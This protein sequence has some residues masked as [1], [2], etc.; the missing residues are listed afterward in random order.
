MAAL[1]KAEPITETLP[2]PVIIVGAGPVG[3]RAAQELRRRSPRLPLVIFGAEAW[4]PYN[5][6]RLSSAL[7]GEVSWASVSREV[8]LPQD[9]LTTAHFG[10]A[11]VAIERQ[12]RRIRDALG[13][14]H[15]YAALIL[16]TGSMP[17]VPDIPGTGLAGV[18]TFRDMND[19]QR[20]LARRVRSRRT[21]VLG[22][23]LL[24]LEAARAMRRFNTEVWVVEH[25]DRLMPRQLDAGA[26]EALIKHVRCAGIRVVLADGARAIVGEGRVEGVRLRSGETLACDTVVIATG[27]VPNTRLARQAGL[28]VGRGI[29][30]DDQ[31]RTSDPHIYAIGECAEHRGQVYGL[32]APGLEQ[33]AVVAHVITGGDARYVGSVTATRLKVL[34]IPVFSVGEAVGE[35]AFDAARHRVYAEPARGVYR[36]VVVRSGRLVGAI[37]VGEWSELSRL[38]EAVQSRRRVWPWQLARFQRTGLLWSGETRHS[39]AQWPSSA[40][41]CNCTGVTRGRLEEA[42][43]AG[44]A[45]VE[46]LSARTG[47]STVCGSCRPL[48]AELIGG[49][50]RPLPARGAKPL[51]VFSAIALTAA[52]LLAFWSMP[53][54]ETADLPWRWDQLWRD[55]FYKQVSGFVLLGFMAALAGLGLRKRLTGFRWGDFAAWRVAHAVLGVAALA[56]LLVHTGGRMGDRLNLLLSAC[57]VGAT[58]AGAF[59]AGVI[60]C[61]H[62]LVAR[63][64][65]RLREASLWIHILLL[66]PLPVLLVFHILKFYWY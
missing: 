31:L 40:T 54:P 5:R 6:V 1:L 52:L 60:A 13:R 36:K 4:H 61:D 15:P 34:R 47:A 63:A 14:A 38:Q 46:E 53:Y 24:G 57:V 41:V 59:A 55:G 2:E 21:V 10:C 29:R 8:I 32:V 19:A 26:A 16:A 37:A 3:V 48:L 51:F 39:V 43:A 44:C 42:L 23:G 35:P 45:T 65:R 64:A 17:H 9:A 58:L 30:V 22:G 12:H 25:C 62:T 28:A 7:A 50:G 56:A 33:A 66:W 20:L 27:I 11:V 49:T 18:Y